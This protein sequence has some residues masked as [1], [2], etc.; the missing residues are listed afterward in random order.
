MSEKYS[1][2]YSGSHV[3]VLLFSVWFLLYCQSILSNIHH[4]PFKN[5]PALVIGHGHIYDNI[6][7]GNNLKYEKIPTYDDVHQKFIGANKNKSDITLQ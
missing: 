3:K 7:Q 1:S 6:T 5:S 4:K 2:I